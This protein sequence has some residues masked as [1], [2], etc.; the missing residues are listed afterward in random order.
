MKLRMFF[1]GS[2]FLNQKILRPRNN[3]IC[4]DCKCCINLF[5]PTFLL[6]DE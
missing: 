1:S 4:I 5:N 3:S 6:T 2:D